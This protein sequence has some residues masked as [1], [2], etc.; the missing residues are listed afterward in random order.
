M[1]SLSDIAAEIKNARKARRLT[2]A[3][4]AHKARVSRARIAALETEK[5]PE[6]GFKTIQ[7]LLRAL[8]LDLRIVPLDQRRPTLDDLIAEENA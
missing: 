5:L 1:L 8:D 4:L 6:M 7:R 2:Q 3:Q